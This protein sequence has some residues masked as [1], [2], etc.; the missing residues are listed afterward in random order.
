M[1]RGYETPE[2]QTFKRN[3]ARL[4]EAAMDALPELADQ[5]HKQ[6]LLSEDNLEAATNV[7]NMKRVRASNLMCIL[8]ERICLDTEVF[9]QVGGIVM[10]IPALEAVQ[11]VFKLE[12]REGERGDRDC[13]PDSK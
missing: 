7:H 2:Y 1:P 6:D 4:T 10:T 3:I 9:E 11:G 5:L 13:A 8:L 12:Q